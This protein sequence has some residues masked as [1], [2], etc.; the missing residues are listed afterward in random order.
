V[1]QEIESEIEVLMYKSRY[2]TELAGS[3]PQSG[4]NL[5]DITASNFQAL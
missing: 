5:K 1:E 2:P 3:K 4:V